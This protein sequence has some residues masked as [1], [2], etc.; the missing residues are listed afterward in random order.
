MKLLYALL[1]VSL[2]VSSAGAEDVR[3]LRRMPCCSNTTMRRHPAL[4]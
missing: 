4:L 1:A 3:Y 2:C